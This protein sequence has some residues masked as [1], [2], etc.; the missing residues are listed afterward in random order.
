MGVDFVV[1]VVGPE[2]LVAYCAMRRL[3]ISGY[4][5][6]GFGLRIHFRNSGFL[7]LKVEILISAKLCNCSL[8]LGDDH[9]QVWFRKFV[10]KFLL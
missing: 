5:G 6:S 4:I 7:H 9:F 1:A 2:I 3:N 8:L 10:P